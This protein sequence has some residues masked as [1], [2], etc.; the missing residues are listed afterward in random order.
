[1]NYA[2]ALSHYLS[3]Y[4]R[5]LDELAP[6]ALEELSV[7]ASQQTFNRDRMAKSRSAARQRRLYRLSCRLRRR[8]VPN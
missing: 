5:F 6:L 1:M 3:H 2:V 8:L 4:S 7:P